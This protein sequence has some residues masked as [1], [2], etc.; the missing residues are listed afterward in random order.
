MPFMPIRHN[1]KSK[2]IKAVCLALVCPV[3]VLPYLLV[4]PVIVANQSRRD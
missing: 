3:A 2:T 4:R 1:R